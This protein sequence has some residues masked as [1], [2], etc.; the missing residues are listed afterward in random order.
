MWFSGSLASP[1]RMLNNQLDRPD[2][3]HTAGRCLPKTDVGG[4][5]SIM[6]VSRCSQCG[7]ELLA[8][9]RF[10]RRC[11]VTV[12]VR[13]ETDPSELPTAVFGGEVET[14]RTQRLDPKP[15]NAERSAFVPPASAAG[16]GASAG[17]KLPATL[18]LGSVIVV[19]IIGIISSLPYVRIKSHSQTT[20]SAALVYPGSQTIVDVTS[21]EDRALQLQ[22]QDSL[23]QVVAWYESN[24]KPG[25]TMRLT[26]TSVVLKNQ[27]VTATIASEAGKTNILIKQ[28]LSP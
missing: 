6:S 19:I 12:V 21:N 10:C 25:K 22:T 20:D 9:A 3:N 11:G 14:P 2:L 23:E 7:A 15:T 26:S 28:R 5:F 16:M 24:L 1:N 4:M 13:Q 27:N 17:R 8:E 18:I